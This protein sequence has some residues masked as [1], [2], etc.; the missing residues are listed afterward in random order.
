VQRA[1]VMSVASLMRPPRGGD[2]AGSISPTDRIAAIAPRVIDS[3]RP[4]AVTASDGTLVG[5][6]TPEQVIDILVGRDGRVS[7]G[8]PLA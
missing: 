4:M 8:E 5:E 3:G 1:K 7:S 2:Y 6:I